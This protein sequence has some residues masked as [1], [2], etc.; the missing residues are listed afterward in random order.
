[1]KPIH[2]AVVLAVLAAG[3]L[4][5]LALDSD[6]AGRGGR[7]ERTRDHTPAPD[8]GTPGYDSRADA[9]PTGDGALSFSLRIV[10]PDGSAAG[11]AEFELHGRE[12]RSVSA[13]EKGELLVG[14]LHPGLYL[15]V[16]RKGSAVGALDFELKEIGDLGILTLANGITALERLGLGL[17]ITP[18]DLESS[19][20]L[21]VWAI[22]SRCSLSSG[23]SIT[24]MSRCQGTT[25]PSPVFMSAG[26]QGS[27]E[28]TSCGSLVT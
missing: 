26:A 12:R 14:G 10:M 25:T 1:M 21:R 7:S 24:S 28:T 20:Q 17:A 27:G 2:L 16:A 19:P 11:D 22:F 15:A 13:D 18:R 5:Y 3:A 9:S 6:G 23:I 8:T 4:L